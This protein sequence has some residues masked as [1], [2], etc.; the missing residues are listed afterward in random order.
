MRTQDP[1]L[2]GRYRVHAESAGLHRAV[3]VVAAALSSHLKPQRSGRRLG[4]TMLILMLAIGTNFRAGAQTITSISPAAAS[5]S[6]FVE[7]LG[8]NFTGTPGKLLI[9]GTVAP[10]ATWTDTRIAAYVPEAASLGSIGV[11]VVTAAG[12]SNG[13]TLTVTDRAPGGRVQWR[14]RM[15][16]PYSEVRP[17]RGPDG[18]IYVIDVYGRLYS[19]AP[20]GALNWLVRNGGNKGLA[21]GPDGTIYTGSESDVKAFNPNG[22]R[23]WVF[24]QNP[25]AFIMLGLS[26]GPDGNIYGVGTEGPGIFSLTPQGTLRWT[27]PEFYSRLIVDY[28][29]IV[30]GRN[31]GEDQLYFYANDHTRAVRLRDGASVFTIRPTGQPVV[32]PLD[33]TMHAT[34]A[35]YSPVGQLQWAFRFPID[36]LPV[37][38][39]DVASDG[40]HYVMWRSSVLYAINPNGTEQWNVTLPFYLGPPNIDPANSLAVVGSANTLDQLNYILGV[41]TSSRQIEWRVDLPAEETTVF[42]PWTGQYGFNQFVDTRAKFSADSQNVYL[43]SAIADGGLVEERSFLY[44]IT[45]GPGSGSPPTAPTNLVAS[46]TTPAR[47]D[48]KWTNTAT[49]ATSISVERCRGGAC[50][51]FKA[52]T[53]LGGTAI[54]WTDSAVKSG[55]TYRYRVRASNAQ[56]NSPYSNIAKVKAR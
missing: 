41:T 34:A 22:T 16:A 11:T 5:R 45:A 9:D 44:A 24:V 50:I 36:N 1:G 21:V 7:I 26:V 31:N 20:N 17:A 33:G 12:V 32:S 37:S 8:T 4:F 52:V 3:N 28:G 56:G 47:I 51:K 10:V 30:F 27:N 35:A 29:E 43:V 40:T 25:R 15:D 49:D 53:Q 42:N 6:G 38:V 48:L 23:K 54:S 55:A 39:P 14:F 46:S 13:V 18:T 2:K 19:L